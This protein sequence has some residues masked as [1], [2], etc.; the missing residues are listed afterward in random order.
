[1]SADNVGVY[2][3]PH[4]WDEQVMLT[5]GGLKSGI[6]RNLDVLKKERDCL[7]CEQPF[8]PLVAHLVG[9]CLCHLFLLELNAACSLFGS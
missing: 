7:R 4:V 3:G 5:G 1:M 8:L 9:L 2:V 6:L